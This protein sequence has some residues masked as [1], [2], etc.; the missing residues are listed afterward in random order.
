[1][2]LGVVL[3][4][5]AT[6]MNGEYAVLLIDLDG[7]IRRWNQH[8]TE[9]EAAHGLPTGSIRATAFAPERLL[10]AITGAISDAA[11]R[12]DVVAALAEYPGAA[13]AIS[14]WSRPSGDLDVQTLALLDRCAPHLKVVL[15]TNAT[16]RLSDDL[17]ALGID[18][19]FHAIINSSE[20]GAAKPD[21]RVYLAALRA[22][23]ANPEQAL[24][25]D[26]SAVNVEAAAAL[27]ITSHCF[28]NHTGLERF[29]ADAG[30]LTGD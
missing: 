28:R 6:G 16:S 29:L 22:A 23:E 25:V 12:R 2:E 3:V 17:R 27:G 10:P 1:M 14:A 7:V 9:I 4:S 30:V 15:V 24:F 21:K 18:N 19:H 26:D 20:I 11:W 5:A 13:Q 8:E